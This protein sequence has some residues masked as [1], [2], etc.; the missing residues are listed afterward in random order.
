MRRRWLVVGSIALVAA[1]TGGGIALSQVTSKP[2]ERSK[3]AK[4]IQSFVEHLAGE[5][6]VSPDRLRAAMKKAG[7]ATVDDAVK[8]GLV[9]KEQAERL[10]QRIEAGEIGDFGL[11]L[12]RF[13]KHRV[14]PRAP[15]RS[16][17]PLLADAKAR[18]S[19]LDAVAKTLGMSRAALVQALA[20]EKGLGELA[21]G[22]KITKEQ[23][24]AAVAG[25]LKPYADRLVTAGR[26]TRER[27]EILLDRIR[28]G[29]FL[30]KIMHLARAA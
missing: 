7:I 24:G 15:H 12:G 14:K 21:E 23:L 25:A 17:A 11:G 30:G 19:V 9:T 8:A 13:A 16:L 22:K 29:A 10:K 2:E 26:I 27:A 18:G 6:G 20:A 1:L 5:L 4:L 3:K 28:T